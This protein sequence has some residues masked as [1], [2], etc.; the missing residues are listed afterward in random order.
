M[1][2][3]CE[4]GPNAWR[5]ASFPPPGEFEVADGIYVLIDDGP[6]AQWAYEFVAE[7]VGP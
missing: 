3:R 5:A 6:P 4:G 2:I 1:M 7:R